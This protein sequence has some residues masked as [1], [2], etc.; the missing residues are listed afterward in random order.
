[1]NKKFLS[2]TGVISIVFVGCTTTYDMEPQ[3]NKEKSTLSIDNVILDSVK[4]K[5]A[6]IKDYIPNENIKTVK[7]TY[8]TES[9]SCKNIYYKNISTSHN[10]FL[11][12]NFEDDYKSHF[13]DK[14]NGRCDITKIANLRFV[15]CKLPT[16]HVY[17]LSS[18]I[19]NS[20][21]RGYSNISE[22]RM[23][24]QSYNKLLS[25]YERKAELDKVEI[26]IYEYKK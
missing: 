4:E 26:N 14:F 3:Y 17:S 15:N 8:I 12:N 9:Y 18:S 22:L 1:M 6:N 23:N 5:K 2:T 11:G 25:H 7:S 24:K 10:T 19:F 21:Y 16:L 20:E 13:V